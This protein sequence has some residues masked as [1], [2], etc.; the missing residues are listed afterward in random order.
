MG[1]RVGIIG[2]CTLLSLLVLPAAST[3]PI[4]INSIIDGDTIKLT[5]GQS[6]R[7]LQIDTPEIRG[8]ECYSLESSQALAKLLTIKGKRKITT[9]PNLDEVDRY[10]R[11]L[12]YLFIGKTNVNL[13]MVELGAA[14]PYFYRKELGKYSKKLLSAAQKAQAK[15]IGLW[16][17]CPS[18]RLDPYSA[19][20]TGSY[21]STESPSKNTSGCDPNYAGCVP[22]FPPDLNCS[23]IRSLG[24][25][26]VRIIGR[27]VHGLDRDGDGVGCD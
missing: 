25:A 3:A 27:D 6:V 13:K 2:L 16:A 1:N 23:D 18:A 19:L 12:R 17:A 11:L 5:T 26:P 4:R 9:D 10:G 22:I 20:S 21:K 8:S 24:L 7:L 14:A 15:K